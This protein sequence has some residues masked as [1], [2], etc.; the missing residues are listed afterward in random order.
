MP[1]IEIGR[2]IRNSVGQ[3][4]IAAIFEEFDPSDFSFLCPQCILLAWGKLA[5]E[6]AKLRS[7][8]TVARCSGSEHA[9][10]CQVWNRDPQ[11]ICGRMLPAQGRPWRLHNDRSKRND[12]AIS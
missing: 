1:P 10:S 2:E 8:K 5:I 4:K 3:I 7:A 9:R 11:A 6:S 12:R